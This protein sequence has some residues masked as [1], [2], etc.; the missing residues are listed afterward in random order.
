[1]NDKPIIVGSGLHAESKLIASFLASK[2]LTINDII[3]IDTD[4]CKTQED[5]KEA[6]DAAR[7]TADKTTVINDVEK[8]LKNVMPPPLTEIIIQPEKGKPFSKF[9]K[10]KRK[11][12]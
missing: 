10:N 1:M 11:K 5:L 7:G 12:W 8:L 9:M 4:T 3:V 2:S 6:I